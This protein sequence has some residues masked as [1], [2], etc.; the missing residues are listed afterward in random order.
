MNS[1]KVSVLDYAEGRVCRHLMIDALVFTGVLGV[2]L[3]IVLGVMLG[4]IMSNFFSAVR[5]LLTLASTFVA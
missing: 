4:T 5:N 3:G 1:F 2:V